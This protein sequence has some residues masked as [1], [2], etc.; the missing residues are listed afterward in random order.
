[1]LKQR[2]RVSNYRYVIIN[3]EDVT[4]RM[5][6]LSTSTN[7][8]DVRKN[9]DETKIILKISQPINDVFLD[10]ELYSNEEILELLNTDSDW[11]DDS[12]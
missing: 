3:I 11:T 10:F 9:N 2:F 1:M 5:L 4:L 8:E 12:E 6:N 7:I